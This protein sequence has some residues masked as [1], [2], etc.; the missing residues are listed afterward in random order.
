MPNVERGLMDLW[1]SHLFKYM[2]PELDLMNNYDQNSQY[3]PWNLDVHTINVVQAIRNETDDLNMLWAGLLHDIA[4]PFTRSDKVTKEFNCKKCMMYVENICTLIG[5]ENTKCTNFKIKSNYIGH[6]VLG[7]EMVK[8]IAGHL[9]WSN[10][11][12]KRVTELV[13]NHLEEDCELRK[14]DNMGKS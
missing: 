14:Y 3:H 2:I 4:K 7:A 11:R 5:D 13:R 12:T 6:E 10:E 8:R 1:Q 9:K